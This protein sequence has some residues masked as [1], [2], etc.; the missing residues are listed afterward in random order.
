MRGERRTFQSRSSGRRSATPTSSWCVE[1]VGKLRRGL[2]TIGRIALQSAVDDLLQLRAD[3]GIDSRGGMGLLS[4]RSFMT[5]KG[6]SP[7]NGTLP[8]SISYSI[9][10]TYKG[11]CA[12]LPVFLSPVPEKCNRVCPWCC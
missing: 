2:I 8:V 7:W 1:V 3:G 10:P 6:F 11:R 9:T 5:A 4:K 12:H